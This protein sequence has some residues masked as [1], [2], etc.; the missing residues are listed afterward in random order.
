GRYDDAMS[1]LLEVK[2]I[3]RAHA[4]RYAAALQLMQNRA[5][6]MERTITTEVLTRWRADGAKL[7]PARRIALLCGHPRSG[8]T[9]LEQVLDAH[10]DILSAEETRLMHDEAYLPLVRDFPGGTSILQ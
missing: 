4:A 1:T 5:R 7:K 3:Q 2:A 6:E 9:L 8:T 10:P